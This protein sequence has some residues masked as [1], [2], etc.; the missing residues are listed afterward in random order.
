MTS[1]TELIR[2]AYYNPEE[3]FVG[4]EKLY[5]KLKSH[6]ISRNDI[7]RFLVKQEVYQLNRKNNTKAASWIPRYPKQEFQIDLIYLDDAHLNR[8]SYGLC[9]IDAF[10]KKADVELM[11]KRTA[12]ETVDAMAQVMK[13]MGVPHMFYCDEGSEFNNAEFKKLCKKLKI[14]LVFTIR[15]APIVERFNRTIK[16]MLSKY[17]QSTNS[18]TITNVLPKIVHN[19]NN[20]FHTTI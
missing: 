3:G 20:S 13:R 9:C 7:S 16:E 12:D 11:K 15:H 8:A 19:Y 2:K 5:R 4:I 18:K 6:G 17:L 1:K 10:T 14:E